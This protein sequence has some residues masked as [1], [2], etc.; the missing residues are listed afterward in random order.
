MKILVCG[1]SGFISGHLIKRLINDGH[2]VVGVDLVE[3]K[4]TQPSQF[5][6]ADL[7]YRDNFDYLLDGVDEVYQLA[8]NMGGC[9]FI[10]TGDNDAE[11]M[12]SA[13]IN[14]NL[15]D[16]L[17]KHK[18]KAKVFYSSSACMYPEH[19]QEQR[20]DTGL[21]ESDWK[22]AGPDS[23]YGWEKL[24]SERLYLA[25]ARNYG[26]DVRIARFHNIYGPEGTWSGGKEK[27]PASISR[28]VAEADRIV[29]CWGS[30]NQ[31][32]S[33]LYIDDCLDA[34][35]LLMNSDF[36][37]PINIGSEEMVSILQLWEM[38]IDI[39]G[40]KIAIN[41]VPMPKNH[42]GVQHRNSNND[43]IREK[44]NWEPKHTLR[45]GMER[46]YRWIEFEVTKN[47]PYPI[48]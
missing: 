4:Y 37:E 33:F 47:T 42:K 18:S 23:E 12:T 41:H 32:R 48:Q 24:F 25:Y 46:L 19:I 5:I 44:L 9:Q 15:C 21:K 3:P 36:K 2:T 40:K 30:G 43:L 7:R 1:S 13:M 10:F 26:L 35:Q 6:Q 8:C 31:T 16:A 39:S 28:K 20:S 17:V 14:L 27:A 11:I 45:E 34:V 22:P 29:D 38:A